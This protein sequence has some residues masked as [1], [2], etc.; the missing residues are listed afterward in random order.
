MSSPEI[1]FLLTPTFLTVISSIVLYYIHGKYA[2][3]KEEASKV[4]DKL[5]LMTFRSLLSFLSSDEASSLIEESIIGATMKI[6][7]ETFMKELERRWPTVRK[8]LGGL[9]SLVN[10]EKKMGYLM[11]NFENSYYYVLISAA[12]SMLLT[13]ASLLT[14][15]LG[16]FNTSMFVAGL[17]AA[18]VMISLYYEKKMMDGFSEY[19]KL[20][21]K[22]L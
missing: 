17:S 20:S 16:L 5:I 13:S 19:F 9:S 11:R 3:V 15:A 6:N 21:S 18:T 12:F 10:M 2:L 4:E 7:G 1:A 8:K 14:F 22:V